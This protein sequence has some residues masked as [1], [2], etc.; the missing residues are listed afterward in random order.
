MLKEE[1]VSK[2]AL[3]LAVIGIILVFGMEQYFSPLEKKTGDIDSFTIGKNVTVRG[4]ISYSTK[5]QN[6]LFFEINDGN[7]ID[8]VLFDKQY[9]NLIQPGEF[10]IVEGKVEKYEEKI[11]IIVKRVVL[12]NN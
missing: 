10:V 8:C 3:S 1:T 4:I 5:K 2:I 6:T 12:W 11:E 9:W 7:K